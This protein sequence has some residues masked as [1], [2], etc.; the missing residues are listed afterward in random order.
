[1][2]QAA[3]VG[4]ATPGALSRATGLLRNSNTT[5][6]NGRALK[7]DLAKR[8]GREVR[9]ANDANCFALSE[10]T[11]GAGAGAEVVFGVILGTGVGGGVAVRGRVVEG[12]NAIAGEWGHNPLPLPAGEDL[13][14]PP[15]YCG[16]SGCIETYLSGP[17][18]SADHARAGGARLAA[19]EIAARAE[20]G[21]A[22]CEASIARYEERL[23]RSLA[24][25]IN[26]LDPDVIVLGGGLS[27]IAA[28]TRGNRALGGMCSPTGARALCPSAR[29]C[30]RAAARPGSGSAMSDATSPR[31]HRGGGAAAAPR[32]VVTRARPLHV[33]PRGPPR[34][35]R[36]RGDRD[37]SA[38]AL[39]VLVLGWSRPRRVMVG[40]HLRCAL[41]VRDEFGL[42]RNYYDRVGHFAQGFVP[43]LV[44]REILL[45]QGVVRHGRWLVLIVT[46][47]CLAISAAYELV[48]GAAAM[49]TGAAADA[50]LG[51]QGD[52]WDTQWDM[53]MALVGAIVAQLTLSKV[54]DRLLRLRP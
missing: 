14:L 10:A 47:I 35:D 45:R 33:V 1:M 34:A 26:V 25:V 3:S 41:L 8:L 20:R 37:L 9:M 29:R 32:L 31:M 30:E 22:G 50:F 39:T 2:G 46:S 11:D 48:E 51:T 7:Q 23:A 18:L 19:E 44:A 54:H 21:D 53:F 4:V 49:A 38:L 24:G 28:S 13:P 52:P 6:L 16:R 15:C 43:A 42:A 17:G 36:G 12:A 27:R 40:G 5:C